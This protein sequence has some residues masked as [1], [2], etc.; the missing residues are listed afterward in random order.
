M[1]HVAAQPDFGGTLTGLTLAT[2]RVDV[3][4]ALLE[5]IVS[6]FA[7]S[8]AMLDRHGID[9]SLVRA[10]GGGAKRDWWLQL[11]SDLTGLPIEVVDQDE[12][13]A[14]GAAILAGVGAGV[15]D[16]VSEAATALVRVARR[17][18]PDARRAGRYVGLRERVAALQA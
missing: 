12:P 2:S 1:P 9:R 17:Y 8:L 5:G 6:R 11:Q 13:G 10:T 18:E 16:S 3:V 4:R 7:G 14:F 15:H